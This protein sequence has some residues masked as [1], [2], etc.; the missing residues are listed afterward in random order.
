M[1]NMN[2]ISPM[3]RVVIC[4]AAC[5]AGMKGINR[6]HSGYKSNPVPMHIVEA[7]SVDG[8]MESP[9]VGVAI[10]FHAN[11]VEGQALNPVSLQ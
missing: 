2:D 10:L 3:W 7:F 8:S 11:L 6:A 4:A 1:I 5:S 9:Q